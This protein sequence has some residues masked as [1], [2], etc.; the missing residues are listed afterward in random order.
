MW[1]D[2]EYVYCFIKDDGLG[3][4]RI[5]FLRIFELFFIIKDVG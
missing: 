2:F 3:I 5:Y 4:K 1:C